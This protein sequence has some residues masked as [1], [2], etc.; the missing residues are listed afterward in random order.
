V[1]FPLHFD[2]G[3]FTLPAHT[4]F[5][6][7]A[8]FIGFRYFLFVRKRQGDL[9]TDNRRTYLIIA[10]IFGAAAGSYFLGA[11]ESP[12]A[13]LHSEDTLI[14]IFSN[15][16]VVGGFLGGLA[17]VE[18][19]KR[20]MK[21]K[22][23]SGDLFVFPLILGLMIGRI[24][25]FSMGI[26][27]PTYGTQSAAGMDLGDGILRHPVALYEIAFLGFLWIGLKKAEQ[28]LMLA[29]GAVFKLF[30]ISYLLFRLLIEFIKP[31]IGIVWG[32]SAIQI[33]CIAGLTWYIP[34]ILQ[35]K[36]LLSYA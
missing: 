16:T 1:S 28:R 3:S 5:E 21:E 20:K 17:G 23:A 36:K 27:E 13:L 12:A 18:I 4:V 10:A 9:F 11:L 19:M 32:V 22:T 31:H 35:P 24:G 30:M 33:A 15:K 25:C 2:F 8:Y 29:N 34:F 26:A 7:A 6:T 14:Y